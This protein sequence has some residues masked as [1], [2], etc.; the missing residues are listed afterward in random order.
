MAK[1]V[2]MICGDYAEDYEVLPTRDLLL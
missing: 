1:N 2:L